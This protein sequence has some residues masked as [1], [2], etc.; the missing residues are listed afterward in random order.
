MLEYLVDACDMF[1]FNYNLRTKE[2][3]VNLPDKLEF[4]CAFLDD[5]TELMYRC[6]SEKEKVEML[7]IT[8]S[9]NVDYDKMSK[10]YLLNVI[11]FLMAYI[12]AKWNKNLRD[13]IQNVVDKQDGARF[14]EIDILNAVTNKSL[15]YYDFHGDKDVERPV[16]EMAKILVNKNLTI[17]SETVKE[18]LSTTIGEIFSNSINHSDQNE[19]FFMYDIIFDGHEFYLCVNIVDYGTTIISNVSQFFA[20][21]KDKEI[22]NKE[23]IKWAIKSGNTTRKGSG[24]YG[25]PTLISYIYNTNGELYI[26]SGDVYYSLCNTKE[27]IMDAK[28]AFDGTSVTFKVKLYDTS[29]KIE[30]NKQKEQLVATISLDSI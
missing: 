2:L 8:C 5:V 16:N 21:E 12:K 17:N 19:V 6:R 7:I 23:C 30:Y 28:G 25:L 11:R 13:Q 27:T 1:G 4:N 10:A 20:K 15:I 18:F 3:F 29:R 22:E 9:S 14:K 24:G 26:F